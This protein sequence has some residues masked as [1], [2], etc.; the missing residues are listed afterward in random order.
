MKLTTR[1]L[2]VFAFFVVITFG[3]TP[4]ARRNPKPAQP[5]AVPFEHAKWAQYWEFSVGITEREFDDAGLQSLSPLQASKL[6]ASIVAHRP[7]LTC[8]VSYG[9]NETQEYQYVHLYVSGPDSD[10]EFVGR[11]RGKLAAIR[12][13]KMIPSEEAADLVITVLTVPNEVGSTKVGITVATNVYEPCVYEIKGGLADGTAR[14]KKLIDGMINA[15][16]DE[17]GVASRVANSLEA[18]DFDQTRKDHAQIIK[19]LQK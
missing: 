18:R 3:Q 11:L 10:A 6:W 19:Y 14:F 5:A 8:G 7:N 12:D 15:G 2:Y 16:G 17:D 1:L 4:S 13:V 9:P